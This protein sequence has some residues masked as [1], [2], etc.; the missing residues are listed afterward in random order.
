MTE[1]IDGSQS[2]ALSQVVVEGMQ[3]KKAEE[4]TVL[5]L[6]EIKNAVADFFVICTG[7]SDT[8][9]DAISDSVEEFVHKKVKENPWHREGT[10]NK[11]WVLLDYVN[12]VAH[13]FRGD[14]RE[15][16]GIEHL[17]G[18]AETTYIAEAS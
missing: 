10:H 9:V 16:F 6:R 4:I 14:T 18:D 12:V 3:E 17:W 2:D 11:D 7:N 13:V 1:I 15:H 5:D 8:H